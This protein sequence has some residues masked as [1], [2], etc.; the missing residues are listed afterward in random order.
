[1]NRETRVEK[2][3]NG[4]SKQTERERQGRKKER[5]GIEEMSGDDRFDT[6][7]A[8]RGVYNRKRIVMEWLGGDGKWTRGC[9]GL[10]VK[11]E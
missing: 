2:E 1:M 6:N 10:G 7:L 9:G 11:K 3:G 8:W 5:E 4:N